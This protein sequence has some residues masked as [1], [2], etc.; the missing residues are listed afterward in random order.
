MVSKLLFLGAL[1]TALS[2]GFVIPDGLENGVYSYDPTT[3]NHT[4]LETP[5]AARDVVG[6]GNSVKFAARGKGPNTKATCGSTILASLDY[7]S[8]LQ[9]LQYSCTGQTVPKHTN[10]YAK[11]GDAMVFMCN[12]AANTCRSSDLTS[13]LGDVNSQCGNTAVGFTTGKSGFVLAIVH[14]KY[15]TRICPG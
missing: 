15:Y 12:Y 13:Y 11:Y 7:G 10:L 5:A 4:K 8:A 3:G 9:Q 1:M 6:L 2:Q 14:T